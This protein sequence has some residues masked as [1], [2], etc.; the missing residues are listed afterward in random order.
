[1]TSEKMEKNEK[2]AVI[3]YLHMKGLSPQQMH[4]DMEK[5]LADDA[6]SQATVYRWVAELKRGRQSTEDEHRSGRPAEASTDENVESIQD[7]ILKGRRLTI[8]R[9]AECLKLSTGTTYQIISEILGYNGVCTRWV[10]QML[11]SEIK[12]VRLQS[13]RDNLELY[14]ADPA[15]FHRRYVT[16]DETWAPHFDP[17]TK[18]QGMQWKHP[19]S[20]PMVK[21]RKTA[22]AGKVIWRW[23]FGT[24]RVF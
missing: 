22:S 12:R 2:R 24:A 5:V 8:R 6:P 16:M 20:P 21:F 9:V 19:T 17:E 3:K 4:E 11:T 13:S 1:M 18:Q 7:M 10:P 23:F 15:K 14:R